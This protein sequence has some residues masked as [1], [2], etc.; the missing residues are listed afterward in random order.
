M[1]IYIKLFSTFS[2]IGSLPNKLPTLSSDYEI[3]FG[4]S[5]LISILIIIGHFP[6]F[7]LMLWFRFV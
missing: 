7:D 5:I 6:K 1:T 2:Q 3:D 4:R